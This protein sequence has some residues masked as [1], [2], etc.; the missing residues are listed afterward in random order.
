MRATIFLVYFLV[1]AC[2]TRPD[3][4]RTLQPELL[5]D[6]EGYAIASCLASQSHP[7]LKDQGDA[8]ASVIIQRMHGDPSVLLDIVE[9]VAVEV[10]KGNMAVM[11]S[12]VE[13]GQDKI[14]PVLFCNEIIYQPKIRSKILEAVKN[15]EPFY[16]K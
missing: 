4:N 6:V 10:E 3:I 1:T 13:P 12:D 8:W 9:Q 14:L 2:A 16:L 7:Y 15:L 11:R 5:R